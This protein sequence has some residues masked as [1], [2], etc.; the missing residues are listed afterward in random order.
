VNSEQS[1]YFLVLTIEKVC[2]QTLHYHRRCQLSVKDS[3]R[4]VSDG[5]FHIFSFNL[6]SLVDLAVTLYVGH[7]KHF[8]IELIDLNSLYLYLCVFLAHWTLTSELLRTSVIIDLGPVYNYD[9]QVQIMWSPNW[10]L[11][12]LLRRK[13]LIVCKCVVF[14]CVN[15]SATITSGRWSCS[16]TVGRWLSVVKPARYRYGTWRQYV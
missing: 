6:F 11:E 9:L 14:L 15:S 7:S 3:K 2:Q 13:N 1:G 8:L 10:K 16:R 12:Y 5:H 4:T